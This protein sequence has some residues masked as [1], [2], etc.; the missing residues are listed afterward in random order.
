MRIYARDVAYAKRFVPKY[1]NL[2]MMES[3]M[4]SESVIQPNVVRRLNKVAQKGP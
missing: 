2:E 3:A 1:S 4:S